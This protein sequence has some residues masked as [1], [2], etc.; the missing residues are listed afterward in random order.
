[1]TPKVIAAVNIGTV[2]I[3]GYLARGDLLSFGLNYYG[4]VLSN[5]IVHIMPFVLKGGAYNP[6]L[7]TALLLFLP[8]SYMVYSQ[9]LKQ[10]ICGKAELVR[11]TAIGFLGHVVII[12]SLLLS[13]LGVVN[14][15]V[16]CLI[17]LLNIL[18]L[19]IK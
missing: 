17:Q 1:M 13:R 2:W 15:A 18:P 3:S 16:A 11:A 4:L 19:A 10:K 7:L 6:G 8:A 9:V 12:I 14:E 5:A